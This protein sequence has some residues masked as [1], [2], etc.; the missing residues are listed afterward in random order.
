[1]REKPLIMIMILKVLQY[2]LHGVNGWFHVEHHMK[3]FGWRP[4]TYTYHR[5]WETCHLCM[6]ASRNWMGVS[7]PTSWIMSWCR[8]EAN[9]HRRALMYPTSMT[10]NE[11]SDFRD[12][13]WLTTQGS[14]MAVMK[15]KVY[16]IAKMD[17][18]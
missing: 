5:N 1:M 9:H 4:L 16:G 7:K 11:C 13:I 3:S 18:D 10:R 15:M 8:Q 2:I 17:F 12:G 6:Q 14:G